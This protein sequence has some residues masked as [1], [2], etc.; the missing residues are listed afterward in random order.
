M[1]TNTISEVLCKQ[2]FRVNIFRKKKLLEFLYEETHTRIKKK[3]KKKKKERKKR[4]NKNVSRDFS[5]CLSFNYV[6]RFAYSEWS[7]PELSR[8]IRNIRNI[9]DFSGEII[10]S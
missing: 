6:T 1:D 4:D 3:K 10:K 2:G 7:T 9:D 8:L 5:K